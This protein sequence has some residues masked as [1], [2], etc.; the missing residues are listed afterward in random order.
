MHKL[1]PI[2]VSLN[3]KEDEIGF[4]IVNLKLKGDDI[5]HVIVNSLKRIIQSDIPIFA[6]NS[7][8]I[9]SNTSVFNNNYIKSHFK[10]SLVLKIKSMNLLLKKRKKKIFP[11]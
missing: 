8:D 7:F 9:T 10:T 4:S 1:K 6:F 5:N 3:E 2:K 11:K